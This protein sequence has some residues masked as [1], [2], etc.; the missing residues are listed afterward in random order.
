MDDSALSD[1]AR[2]SG[3]DI[4]T[5]L[6]ALHRESVAYWDALNTATFLAPIGTAWSPAENVRHLTKSMRAVTQG[7]Q[8]P[9]VVL[10]V[11]FGR[12]TAPSRP[13]A[14]VR[15]V[16][17]ARLAQGASAGRFAP[18]PHAAPSNPEDARARTMA[19]HAAAVASLCDAVERWPE[20]ALDA[21][22]LPHPLLGRLTVRE[23]L[24]FTLYHNRHHLENVQRRFASIQ[25]GAT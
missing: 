16:Y 19:A 6:H 20:R 4:R 9:R 3:S 13:Y 2:S 14:A 24:F 22:R 25:T 21:R 10:L 5:A 8:L 15:E 17:R 23:M 11:A 7:L 18:R 12:A 1:S